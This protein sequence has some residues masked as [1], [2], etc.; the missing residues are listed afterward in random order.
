MLS[1]TFSLLDRHY[2]DDLAYT[3]NIDKYMKLR[4]IVDPNTAEEY[5]RMDYYR[6]YNKIVI[7]FEDILVK[8]KK[9]EKFINDVIKFYDRKKHEVPYIK[10]KK[11]YTKNKK[12]I[13]YYKYLDFLFFYIVKYYSNLKK[14][15]K[16]SNIQFNKSIVQGFYDYNK[17]KWCWKV[18]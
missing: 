13:F 1:D 6:K 4:N 14:N 5:N 16:I 11:I 2:V 9:N 12:N 7:L 3:S 18:R 10:K 8:I 17:N 15:I